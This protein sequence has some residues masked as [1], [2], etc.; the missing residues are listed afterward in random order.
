MGITWKIKS[1]SC[2]ATEAATVA[3]RKSEIFLKILF[4]T[5]VAFLYFTSIINILLLISFNEYC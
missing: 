5:T 4:F 2:T 3:V 1:R